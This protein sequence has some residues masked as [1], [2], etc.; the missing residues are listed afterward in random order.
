M[1]YVDEIAGQFFPAL[2]TYLDG[3]ARRESGQTAEFIDP[4]AVQGTPVVGNTEVA[5]QP[6]AQLRAISV[7]GLSIGSL[8]LIAGVV[9]LV[10][11][12]AD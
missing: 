8:L 7:G 12:V 1:D 4:N 9:W 5:P 6:E 2:G 10:V 11:K 3:I